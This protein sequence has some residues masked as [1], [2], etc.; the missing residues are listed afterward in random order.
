[1]QG[2]AKMSGEKS[3]LTIEE[4]L[5]VWENQLDKYLDSIGVNSIISNPEVEELLTLKRQELEAMTPEQLGESAYLLSQYAAFVKKQINRNRNRV[6]W[7]QDRLD[8]LIGIEFSKYKLQNEVVKHDVVVSR[9][10][11]GN[12]VAGKLKSVILHAQGRL[13]EL[14]DLPFALN[15][16]AK[17][18][19]ELQQSKRFKK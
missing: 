11:S 1:M 10:V 14:E 19:L 8:M 15:N 12:S 7:A 2:I 16:M 13:N 17:S 18:L 4:Q 3:S 5:K 6:F 9:I